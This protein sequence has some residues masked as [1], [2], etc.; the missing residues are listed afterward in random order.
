MTGLNL[1]SGD[2]ADVAPAGWVNVDRYRMSHWRRQPDVM[3]NVLDGLPFPDDHFDRC[4]M[5]HFLEHLGYEDE[6]PVALAEV[7][8]VCRDGAPVMV[9]GPDH[10]KAAEQLCSQE[11][12]D[13]I[14]PGHEVR[15][16]A[17]IH[18]RWRSTAAATL[19]ALHRWLD[20]NAVEVLVSDVCLP[21]WPNPVPDAL[22]QLAVSATVLK[23]K[24]M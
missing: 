7:R 8:R 22:W 1:G 2:H 17:G 23:R 3:A 24:G 11:L 13:I 20:P 6:I 19:E 18:H 9:V 14:W 5:G 16:P 10:V 4:Y 12:L 15:E 21:E